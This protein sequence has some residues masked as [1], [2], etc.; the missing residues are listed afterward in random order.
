MYTLALFFIIIFYLQPH[1][2]RNC[3]CAFLFYLYSSFFCINYFP[4]I[5][6]QELISCLLIASGHYWACTA[7]W[8]THLSIKSLLTSYKF[9]FYLKLRKAQL[10]QES[11]AWLMPVYWGNFKPRGMISVHGLR[12]SD[13][14]GSRKPNRTRPLISAYGLI[15]N[16]A[17][18]SGG[19]YGQRAN[20]VCKNCCL[21]KGPSQ[22]L[23]WTPHASICL[24][25]F[26][27]I[28]R[29]Q[30]LKTHWNHSCENG[31]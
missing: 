22:R 29:N 6:T 11:S 20:I 13:P 31:F 25:D 24:L 2:G 28:R 7:D 23:K 26:L 5:S 17:T 30:Q 27:F 8:V 19:A 21:I 15:K 10:F 18:F 14:R 9:L 3:V 12:V 16:G 1:V 4:H